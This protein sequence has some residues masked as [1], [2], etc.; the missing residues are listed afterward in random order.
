MIKNYFKTALRNL[1]KNKLYTFI[2][3]LGLTTGI[4]SC[5]FLGLY[6]GDELSY[7]KFHSNADR[8]ARVTMEYSNGGTI[9]KFAQTGTKVGPQFSRSFPDIEA[10]VRTFKFGRVV[11]NG[12]KVFDEKNI[13]Y[14]DSSFFNIFSFSLV[15]G[16]PLTALNAPYQ[17]VLTKKMALKYFGKED[18]MGK[19]LKMSSSDNYT[20][21]GIAVDPPENSQ[22]RFDFVASFNSLDD[23][24]TEDWWTANDITYLLLNNPTS[25]TRLQE[26]IS[27]FMKSPQIRKQAGVTGNDYLTYHLEPLKKVHLYSP[28]AGSE[29][30]GNITYIYVLGLIALLILAIACVNYT[31]LSTAQ[32]SSR[33]GEISIRKVMGARR[34][35]I[36]GQYLGESAML[37]GIA[38]LFAVL[39]CIEL[40]PLFNRLSDKSLSISLLLHPVPLIF[41]FGLGIL[42]CLLSGAYP[43]FVLSG[44]KLINLLKN[45]FRFSST[46]GSLRKVLIVFQFIISVFLVISTIIILQ[47][48]S[49]IRNKN[50]GYEKEHVLVLPVDPRMHRDYD[51]IKTS[52]GL[53]PQVQSVGG[54]YESPT[55][56]QWG[57]GI[58]VDNGS[59]K[60]ELTVTCL[61]SDLDLVKTLRMQIIAGSDF[62]PADLLRMDTSFNYKNFHYTFILNEAAVKAIGWKPEEAIGKTII[63]G[64]PGTVKA[65]IKD[66]NFSSL[67]EAIS[68]MV[69]FLDTQYIH[70]M[71]VRISGKD[72]PGTLAYLQTLWKERVPYRPF[73]Y[74]FLDEDYN[75]L[76]KVETRAGQLFSVFSGIAIFLACMGLFALAAFTT[77]QRTKEIGIRKVLGASLLNI[78][79]LLS[80]D[81]LKLVF[82]AAILAIPLAWWA[83]YDWL[84]DFA[85]R[86][87]IRWWVFF[88]STGLAL[89]IAL[90]TISFH[91]IRAA[92]ANPA[93]SLRTE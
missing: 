13:L 50:L 28:L 18:A 19:S 73:E 9:G 24:R 58:Q 46:S 56:V 63:K 66:F 89:L 11:S 23:S 32:S 10:F 30:N 3:V 35:Q 2:N 76:Y 53:Y 72:I 48:L 49:F 20:V 43:A 38:L 79:G 52:I 47:Q 41:L 8:I 44:A 61:P 92:I 67:H 1:R 55:H 65:V 90:L 45:G 37:S 21:T 27:A 70:Q 81:F 75:A 83:G 31:N 34:W 71:F 51:A 62:S 29:P 57:D 68:P 64:A 74:H 78:T 87:E 17:I 15:R 59:R 80:K 54:A 42:V 4:S 86:I 91:A 7:D 88:L 84:E 40:L 33:N 39:L 69:L 25:F 12:E 14:A 16:N 6:I 82:I 77:L 60:K 5:I 93:E 85:Y 36:F 26:Q 22:I